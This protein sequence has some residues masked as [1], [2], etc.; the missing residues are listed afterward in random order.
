MP[1]KNDE[2]IKFCTEYFN[3]LNDAKDGKSIFFDSNIMETFM[4][5][6]NSELKF[7]ESLIV[8]GKKVKKKVGKIDEPF[9][10]FVTTVSLA[11]ENYK[12]SVTNA[13]N[14]AHEHKGVKYSDIHASE[15]ET[16]KWIAKTIVDA[17][18]T[19]KKALNDA[20][21]KYRDKSKKYHWYKSS[22]G[23]AEI[24]NRFSGGSLDSWLRESRMSM[25]AAGEDD[26]INLYNGW[27][28]ISVGF[29]GGFTI[30]HRAEKWI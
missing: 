8:G 25:R 20:T 30:K 18:D 21:S 19:L 14:K 4:E 17:I 11:I 23:R 12:T 22:V 7:E 27:A 10:N 28:L 6:L 15:K 13:L 9:K 29:I 16:R 24:A 1:D 26:Y 3:I 5:A 2:K